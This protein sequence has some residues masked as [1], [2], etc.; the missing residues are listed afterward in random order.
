MIK[1]SEIM[2]S[3]NQYDHDGYMFDEGIFLYFGD[4]VQIK[5][6]ETI[7]DY[8]AF[9]KKISDMRKEISEKPYVKST[10]SSIEKVIQQ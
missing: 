9:I 7:E 6:A 1:P 2:F 4:N 5:V 3:V 10:N 8:D